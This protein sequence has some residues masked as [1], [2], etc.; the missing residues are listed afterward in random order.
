ATRLFLYRGDMKKEW[1]AYSP[2]TEQIFQRFVSGINTYVDWLEA[3]PDKLPFE[4]KYLH[5]KPAYWTAEDAIRIR[6]HGYLYNLANEVARAK[7]AC[8]EGL[9]WDE[10]RYKLEPPWETRIPDGLD[11]CLP[12]NVLKTYNLATQEVHFVPGSLT[13]AADELL[14]GSIYALEAEI[15]AES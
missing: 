8:S 9:K 6:T 2:D 10:F 7:V 14:P 5:Y 1:A 15:P 11:P 3:H 12:E 13:T 4:F